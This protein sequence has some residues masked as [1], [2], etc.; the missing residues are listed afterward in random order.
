MTVAT[1]LYKWNNTL[2]Y[3]MDDWK[4]CFEKIYFLYKNVRLQMDS[5]KSSCSQKQQYPEKTLRLKALRKS[6]FLE[7]VAVP[8]V[9][10]ASAIVYNCSSKI[11]LCFTAITAIY[12]TYC[13][14]CCEVVKLTE[15]NRSKSHPCKW[16]CLQLLF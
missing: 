8:K 1:S 10:L 6:S 15:S 5:L 3:Q 2:L 11:L 13:S 4:W 14:Y 16:K 12:Y 7:R 9:T